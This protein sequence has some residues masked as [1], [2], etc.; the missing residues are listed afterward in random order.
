MTKNERRTRDGKSYNL[1]GKGTAVC[2]DRLVKL[3]QS[4]FMGTR[5][6]HGKRVFE[7]G[8]ENSFS[9]KGSSCKRLVKKK[10]GRQESHRITYIARKGKHLALNKTAQNTTILS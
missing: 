6:Y 8:S 7:N 5:L 9:E 1:C 2:R 4:I 3:F 10:S